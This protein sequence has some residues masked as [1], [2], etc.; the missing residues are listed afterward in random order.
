M[1][2]G[3]GLLGTREDLTEERGRERHSTHVVG[4]R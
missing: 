4:R 1:T 3:R 2:T